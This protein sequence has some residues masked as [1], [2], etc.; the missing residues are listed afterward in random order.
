MADSSAEADVVPQ[1]QVR[2]AGAR[3]RLK[4]CVWREMLWGPEGTVPFQQGLEVRVRAHREFITPGPQEAPLP[5]P[6][7]VQAVDTLWGQ[8]G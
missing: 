6:T 7:P 4:V 3:P 1:P 2:A 5:A 8:T